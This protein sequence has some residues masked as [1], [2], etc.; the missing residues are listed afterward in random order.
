MPTLSPELAQLPTLRPEGVLQPT[1]C[2]E[3]AGDQVKPHKIFLSYLLP[4]GQ[5]RGKFQ[6]NIY[7]SD[8]LHQ[9]EKSQLATS[10]GQILQTLLPP[11]AG[12]ISTSYLQWAGTTDPTN[13]I[14]RGSH[15]QLPALDRSYKP[16]PPPIPQPIV[17]LLLPT[18]PLTPT[19][20]LC[21]LGSGSL[22]HLP[23]SQINVQSEHLPVFGALKFLTCFG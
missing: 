17:L 9:Q 1:A 19:P 13:F 5:H 20:A 23:V 4:P 2:P 8:H 18:L 21:S 10:S 14:S 11:P 6:S 3:Q 16:H 12:G 22:I 15:Y 7:K